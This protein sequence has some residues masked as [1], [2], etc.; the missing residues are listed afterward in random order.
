MITV[1]DGPDDA[2]IAQVV[3]PA[4]EDPG[5]TCGMTDAGSSKAADCRTLLSIMDELVGDGTASLNWD[6][7]TAITEWDGLAAGTDRVRGIYLPNSG[8]A[9]TLPAGISALDALERLTLTD[10]DLT[11]EIPDL[12]DLDNLTLLVLGGNAFTGGNPG[13]PGYLTCR[14]S[15]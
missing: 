2:T 15:C 3:G 8:L 11:G 7:D 13:D 1:T 10:N 4:P 12:S 14:D 5:D 9:G 6:E